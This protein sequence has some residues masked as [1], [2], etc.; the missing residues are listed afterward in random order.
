MPKYGKR[1][2]DATFSCLGLVFL[3]PLF[4]LTAFCIKCNSRGPVFFRQFRVG[5]N[6]RLFQILK[7]RSMKESASLA[8]AGVTVLGDARITGVGRIL[9]R[10]KLDELPQLWNVLFGDMSLVGPRPELPRFV[11]AYSPEQRLVL[12][13]RPGITD[14]AS[15]FYRREEEILSLSPDPEETY[16]KQVLPDKLAQNLTYISAISF[17]NDLRIIWT[18]M[19]HSFLLGGLLHSK[20]VAGRP[21]ETNAEIPGR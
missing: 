14:P 18:T 17:Q 19:R 5:K 1:I 9:R 20:P 3:S 21:R 8:P 12:S 7:F 15:L 2:V 6:G 10:F 4:A 11:V 16:L 13:V